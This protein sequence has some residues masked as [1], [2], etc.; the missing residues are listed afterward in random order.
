MTNF[1]QIVITTLRI[2]QLNLLNNTSLFERI[3]D[4]SCKDM[5]TNATVCHCLQLPL[6]DPEGGV[7]GVA[8]PPLIFKKNS[9]HPRGCCNA[10]LCA[11]NGVLPSLVKTISQRSRQRYW[12]LSRRLDR[13]RDS[14]AVMCV[15]LQRRHVR[16]NASYVPNAK[17]PVCP[18]CSR[19]LYP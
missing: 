17:M 9:G 16:H 8:T 19:G 12:P 4:K 10:C 5:W 6:A 13:S 11:L 2:I 14:K 1:H 7:A 18:L 15:C 3:H